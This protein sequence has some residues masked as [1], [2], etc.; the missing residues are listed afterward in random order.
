MTLGA[1]SRL[2]PY[3]I[4]ELI[5][6]GGM[7]EVY[8]AR[9][10]R[11][12]RYVAIKIL[13]AGIAD[14][15]GR[16]HR[17]EQEAR[18]VAALNHPHILT[19]FDIGS[20]D[21][22][23]YVVTELLDGE[24]L[25]EVLARRPPTQRQVLT[26]AVQVAQGL[27]AAHQKGIVH[28]DVKPENL[29]LTAEGRAKILDFGLARFGA[30]LKSSSP[31]ETK[32]DVTRAGFLMGTV[33]YM[34]PEQAS[35]L[36]IDPRSDL[37]SFGIVLYEL[38]SGRHPFRR[39]TAEATVEAI[40]Y[41]TP[42]APSSL[43]PTIPPAL[44]G[45]VRRCLEKDREE[46]FQSAHELAVALEAVLKAPPGAASLAAA[47]ERSPYPGLQSFTEKNA[48]AFFG[49]ET[50]VKALWQRLESRRLLAVI[51]PSGAGKTSFVR[52]GVV[53]SRPE[54]WGAIV[55]KPGAAPLRNLANAVAPELANDPEA[56]TQLL[57]SDEPEIALEMLSRWRGAHAEALLVVDQFEE[58]FTLNPPE[59]QACFA[60]LLGRLASETDIHVLLSLRDDFL[61]RC[62]DR[63]PLGAIF[64]DLTPL[65][66]LTADGLRRALI[67]PARKLGYR[68]EDDA[69]VNEMVAS[70]EGARGALPLLAFAVARLWEKRE[71][72]TKFLTWEAYEEIGG[73]A[74]ALAQHAEATMARIGSERH[75]IVREMFRQLVTAQ[76]TRAVLDREEL[77]SAFQ[78][79]AAADEVLGALIDAR[80]LTSYEVAEAEGRS[81]RHRVEIVHESLLEAW[82]RLVRWQ[83]QDEEGALLRDQLR[84]AA[85]L[86]S[87]K[88]RTGDLLWTG[89]AYEEFEL[90]RERYPG[91]LTSAESDFARAM[92]SKAR[93]RKRLL[94]TT[95]ASVIVALATI[96]VTIGILGYRAARSRDRAEAEAQRAEAGKLLAL[97]RAAVASDSTSPLAYVR[98]SLELADT[99]EARRFAVEVLWR[100]P[101][102]R[103]L[104]P[105]TSAEGLAPGEI[106][107]WPS[108]PVLDP[109]SK[110]LAL[111]NPASGRV[112][113]FPNDGSAPRVLP[114]SPDG[115]A[116]ALAFGPGGDLL[117]TNGPGSSLRFLSLPDLREVGTVE[118][119]GVSSD[120][121]VAGDRL[122]TSTRLSREDAQTL[123]RSWPLPAGE[124]TVV[125]RFEPP[126]ARTR[127]LDPTGKW[128]AY[129]HE[130]TIFLRA[131]APIG[132]S[133][134]RVLGRLEGDPWDDNPLKIFQDG[135]GLV[136]LEQPGVIRLWTIGG[137]E[138]P[139]V[140]RRGKAVGL[141]DVSREASHL[142][143]IDLDGIAL[144][145]LRDPPDAE[146]A[147]LRFESNT[148]L[149]GGFD[150]KAQWLV[151]GSGNKYYFWPVRTPRRR[152]LPH[153]GSG[154]WRLEFTPDG[155]WLASSAIGEPVRLWPMNPRDGSFRDLVPRVPSWNV[156]ANAASTRLLVGTWAFSQS[157]PADGRVFLFPI[158]GGAPRQLRTGWEG[159]AGTYAVA[160]DPRG[161]LAV[162]TPA[163]DFGSR[164]DLALHVLKTWDLESGKERTFPIANLTG[165][166]W[167]GCESFQFAPNGV[168]YCASQGG[169][170]RLEIPNDL[171]GTLSGENIYPASR[172]R[173]AL[174]PDGRR[175]LV[176]ASTGHDPNTSVFED[177]VLVDLTTGHRS[178]ITTHGQRLF[179]AAFDPTG[180]IIV[181]GDVEG[182]VRVGLATGEEPHLLLGHRAQYV[183]SLAV[184]PDGRWI[185]SV[186]LDDLFLWPMPD[187]K[188]PPLHILPHG[189]LLRT[190]DSVTNLRVVP[191][192]SSSTGWRLDVGPFPGWKD[193]PAW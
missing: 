27:A 183:E 7:G 144:W 39:E 38:L 173:F 24:N 124:P 95:V 91:K 103:I 165:A 189:E 9:D 149:V 18:A 177:L 15:A 121:W 127:K 80:L 78:E 85:R 145:D 134:D 142:A 130:R 181:T 97:A 43:E 117:I 120:A 77:L 70:V 164:G 90:W 6:V 136:S 44:D 168:L 143:G 89:T 31:G 185:A 17:F 4:V 111:R 190:L 3:E 182:I 179:T 187:V 42:P 123:I 138:R 129:E 84:Q 156:V 53:A 163:I 23:P 104:S 68:F 139:R 98:K 87:E 174:S 110:W 51:G 47:E 128:L 82:P 50:E 171:S 172:A 150:S 148:T 8:R 152:V 26:M 19:L 69:L 161:R 162:A 16:L 57:S 56:V 170:L 157:G 28:R 119:G 188:K 29:F 118:L 65:G 41:E 1:G 12:G 176:L 75:G 107:S 13:P 76:G 116:S 114:P 30:P 106:S 33:A 2:G 21:G 154:T 86:W 72:E 66:P 175:L 191:D 115:N 55:C 64:S 37:F 62:H 36:S 10:P 34:S 92:A 155:R 93:R 25:R 160:F 100:G 71:R 54:G 131:L 102:A 158:A 178:R 11:L 67:E 63:E 146:A 40:L 14:D 105:G 22:T 133:S 45:I 140:L 99:P 108:L 59:S 49:R 112:F 79:R 46:R 58:L 96:A 20:H 94:R 159:V 73:V 193:V 184:S 169:V 32:G 61:M 180:K 88:N 60:A 141:L 137:G 167:M 122:L 166:D 83:T 109:E 192:P 35:A 5:G 125:A 113:L 151:T 132:P 48:G 81:T 52:A 135:R 186:G 126:S 153:H 101:A 147:L 74:G